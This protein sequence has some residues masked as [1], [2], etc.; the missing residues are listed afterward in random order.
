MSDTPNSSRP[1]RLRRPLLLAAALA[2]A[3]VGAYALVRWRAAESPAEHQALVGRYCLDCHSAAERSGELSLEGVDFAA[4]GQNPEIW[5][6]VVRKL[7]VA[8]M[9][10]AD[11]PQPEATARVAFV[12]WLERRLDRAAAESPDP[13]PSLVRRRESRRVRE[14][15]PGS[16]A[17]RGRCGGVA[18]S[19][20]LRVRLRQHRRCAD[21][22]AC[23]RRAVLER[24][25]QDRGARRRRSRNGAGCTSV[26]HSSG[27][28]A[29]HSGRR[30]AA[31][32]GRRRNGPRRAAARRGVPA[33]RH[34][35]QVQSRRDEGPRASA[36]LRDR[37]RRRAR[38]PR[39]DRRHRGLHGPDAQHHGGSGRRREAQLDRPCR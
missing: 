15:G 36:R 39:D 37:R 20:R 9:P 6:A 21:D 11:A 8:M 26:P 14:R 31:R 18:A 28:V 7:R 34:L 3:G 33:R 1:G 5:E 23:A 16:S 25:R 30:H 32:H 38:P 27:R 10:P 13:G 4:I 19:R 12:A 22:L 35:L 2:V 29:G 24:G 17:R